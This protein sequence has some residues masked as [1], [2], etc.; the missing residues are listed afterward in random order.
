MDE[1]LKYFP[2]LS[3]KKV[4]LLQEYVDR[5]LWWNARINLISRQDTA[6]LAERHILHSLS[7]AKLIRFPE[8]SLI[9]DLGTGGGL[10]GIPLA[11][12][13]PNCAF[14]LIDGRGKKITAVQSMISDLHLKNVNAIHTRAEDFKGEFDF[15]VAR[16][17]ASMAE[18]WN[19]AKPMF[20][21]PQSP[22]LLPGKGETGKAGEIGNQNKLW[23]VLTAPLGEDSAIW[24]RGLIALK[25]GDLSAEIA[26]MEQ[27]G[28]HVHLVPI[29]SLFSE[30]Y[31]L[32]KFI[33]F[34]Q[35]K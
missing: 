34:I 9:L 32:E 30:P 25:G 21:D 26:E 14:T 7:I 11:I 15:V 1:I 3:Q 29:D 35:V 13:F 4:E 12:C 16:A 5:L 19:W 17:V 24:E 28:Q 31:F 23:K 33:V 10:P 18:L 22:G 2:N 8:G 20:G 6:D 27:I